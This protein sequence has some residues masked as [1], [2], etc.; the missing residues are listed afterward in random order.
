SKRKK[1]YKSLEESIKNMPFIYKDMDS[2]VLTDFQEITVNPIPSKDLILQHFAPERSKTFQFSFSFKFNEYPKI[3]LVGEAGMG[4]STFMRHVTLSILRKQKLP[5]VANVINLFP[6]FVPLK[7]IAN[8]NKSPIL[9]YVLNDPFFKGKK[10]EHK[11][12]KFARQK[13]LFIFL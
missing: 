3:L 13:K 5:N 9:A 4:K 6:I 12:I 8:T 1:Y 2:Q 7:L 11:L 10:G